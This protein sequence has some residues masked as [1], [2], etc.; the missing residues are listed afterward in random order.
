MIILVTPITIKSSFEPIPIYPLCRDRAADFTVLKERKPDAPLFDLARLPV[1]FEFVCQWMEAFIFCCP[2]WYLTV[3]PRHLVKRLTHHERQSVP[4]W[5]NTGMRV[6]H[7]FPLGGA[8]S[9]RPLVG[10][11]GAI[12]HQLSPQL[13]HFPSTEPSEYFVNLTSSLFDECEER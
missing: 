8:R 6:F 4:L 13:K 10:F 2:D 1:E 12:S 9:I 5:K 3:P 7:G 11:T